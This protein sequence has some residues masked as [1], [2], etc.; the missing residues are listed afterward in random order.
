MS[1]KKTIMIVDDEPSVRQLVKNALDNDFAVIE[2]ID[3]DE[4]VSVARSESPALILMDILMPKK[5]GL[6]AC[7]E[8]KADTTTKAIPVVMLTGISQELDRKLCISLGA[9]EYIIKPFN[10]DTLSDVVHRLANNHNQ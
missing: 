3:G 6:Q 9:D 2:A 4:A 8:I 5:D 1:S 10:V 7:Y